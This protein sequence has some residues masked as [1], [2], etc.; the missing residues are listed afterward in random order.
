M[1][2]A[3]VLVMRSLS[4]QLLTDELGTIELGDLL[5]RQ[6]SEQ[7]DPLRI[8][9]PDFREVEAHRFASGQSRIA[10]APEFLDRWAHKLALQLKTGCFPRL[11]RH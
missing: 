7:G 9:E 11:A 6:V 3:N 2:P 10:Q 8:H 5:L 4:L 1:L